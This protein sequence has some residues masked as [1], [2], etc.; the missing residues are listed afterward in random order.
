MGVNNNEK[1]TISRNNVE[2]VTAEAG[3]ISTYWDTTFWVSVD[4]NI[5]EVGTEDSDEFM[6]AI[7]DEPIGAKYI[8][9]VAGEEERVVYDW[10]FYK[11]FYYS[12]AT[13]K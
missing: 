3:Q 2:I 10:K 9:F 4:G 7:L 12:S 1:S 5:I 8:W 13:G 11:Y 6:V